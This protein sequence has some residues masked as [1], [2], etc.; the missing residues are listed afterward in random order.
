[1]GAA[2]GVKEGKVDG[3]NV[4]VS[5]GPPVGNVEG[6]VVGPFV[7]VNDGMAVGASVGGVVGGDRHVQ[8]QV[9]RTGQVPLEFV[10]VKLA[11]HFVW[12][13]SSEARSP[14][15]A[16]RMTPMLTFV[17]SVTTIV[18]VKLHRRLFGSLAN[19]KGLNSRLFRY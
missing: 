17:C 2:D 7:G 4:G 18:D 19:Q 12:E 11:Q 14:R 3:S 1:M 8:E 15:I 10:S 16:T 5:V 6:A 13:K 9:Q